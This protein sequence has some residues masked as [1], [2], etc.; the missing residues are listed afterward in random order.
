MEVVDRL[1]DL[2]LSGDVLAARVYL[3][4]VLGPVRPTPKVLPLAVPNKRTAE[5]IEKSVRGVLA[6]QLAALQKK[7]RTEGLTASELSIVAQSVE[8]IREVNRNL[9]LSRL[10]GQ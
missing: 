2:A 7:A 4:R 1:R 8:A 6:G 3:D 5:A 10:F 9:E